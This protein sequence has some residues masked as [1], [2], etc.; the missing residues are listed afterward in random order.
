MDAEPAP[1]LSNSTVT[2]DDVQVRA[3]IKYLDSNTDFREYL[4]LFRVPYYLRPTSIVDRCRVRNGSGSIDWRYLSCVAAI[5]AVVAVLLTS[6][7]G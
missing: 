3:T 7:R 2:L 5:I 4:P 6:Y 1:K